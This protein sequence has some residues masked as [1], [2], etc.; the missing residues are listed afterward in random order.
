MSDNYLNVMIEAVGSDN[1]E[2][3]E[4]GIVCIKLSGF[5]EVFQS[6]VKFKLKEAAIAV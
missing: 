2:K 1:G 3:A 5:I 4:E 6:N